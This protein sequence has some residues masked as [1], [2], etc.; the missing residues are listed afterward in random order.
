MFAGS[1]ERIP[2]LLALFTRI[3]LISFDF[4]LLRLRVFD[5]VTLKVIGCFCVLDIRNIKSFLENDLRGHRDRHLSDYLTHQ[6]AI[7][8]L[9]TDCL[10][11][12]S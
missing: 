5:I 4:F 6:P 12:F 9:L 7:G 3:V 8:Q 1:T 2:P 10:L 11:K